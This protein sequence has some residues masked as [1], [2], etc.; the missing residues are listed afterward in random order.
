M[1]IV[2][3]SHD[4]ATIFNI[5]ES[6]IFRRL[7]NLARTV[8]PDYF[9]PNRNMI[10]GELLDINW[11]SYRTKITKDLMAGAEVFGLVFLRDLARIKE[12]PLIKTLHPHSMSP[13]LY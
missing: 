11:K 2:D 12:C 1:A 4:E 10:G 6:D 13:W 7:I 3:L 5:G 8:G 9:P